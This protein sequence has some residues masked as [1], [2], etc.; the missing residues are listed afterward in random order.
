M[1]P[2]RET[3]NYVMRVTETLP[4]YEAR[5]KGESGELNFTAMLKRR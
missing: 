4:I 5:L 2:F 3:Q 1:I